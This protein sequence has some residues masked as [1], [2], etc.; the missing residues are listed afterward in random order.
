M[1]INITRFFQDAD[2]F[3][4]SASVAERGQNAGKETWSNAVREGT[5]SPLLK[6]PEE[7]QALRDYVRGFGAWD[8]EEI[9][10]WSDAECNA[11]FVQLISGDMRE[12]ESLC[13]GDDG[14]ID[15][16]RYEELANEG[17]ISGSIYRADIGDNVGDIFYYLGS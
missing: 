12:M 16:T 4:F 14:E 10:A 6:T 7:L 8:D 3:E 15:W 9:A 2:A 1:E 17:T 5:D 13:I 11:L